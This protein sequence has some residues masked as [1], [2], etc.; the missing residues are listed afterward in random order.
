[1]SCIFCFK[2]AGP[3]WHVVDL[4]VFYSVYPIINLGIDWELLHLYLGLVVP[5]LDLGVC[6]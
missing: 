4:Y 2:G 1:M 5:G 3:L 6:L